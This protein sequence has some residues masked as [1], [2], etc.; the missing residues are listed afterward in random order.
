MAVIVITKMKKP[1]KGDAYFKKVKICAMFENT[2][3]N[4]VD[5]VSSVHWQELCGISPRPL[6]IL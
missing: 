2:R 1:S 3:M 6:H 4:S 5:H